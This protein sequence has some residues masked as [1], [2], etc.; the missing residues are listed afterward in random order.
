MGWLEE[1]P[2]N[3]YASV[4]LLDNKIMNYKIGNRAWKHPFDMTWRFPLPDNIDEYSV[5]SNCWE[6]NNSEEH[7]EAFNMGREW[8]KQWEVHEDY[9]GFDPY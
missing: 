4:L 1:Y 3:V 5:Q 9:K 8:M 6:V 7:N 2:H